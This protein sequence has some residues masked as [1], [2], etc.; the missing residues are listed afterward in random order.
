MVRGLSKS[1]QPIETKKNPTQLSPFFFEIMRSVPISHH[2][3]A[4]GELGEGSEI[5]RSGSGCPSDRSP[6]DWMRKKGEHFTIMTLTEMVV[7]MET[8]CERER[9]E[10]WR[11]YRSIISITGG[12]V[13]G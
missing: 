8:G 11:R 6:L 13:V 12:P 3:A 7:R 1:G 5:T 10:V 2:H 9:K 4:L